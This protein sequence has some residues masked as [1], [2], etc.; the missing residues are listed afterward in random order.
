MLW[1]RRWRCSG[2]WRPDEVPDVMRL[3]LQIFAG[4][5]GIVRR[6]AR[7]RCHHAIGDGQ[8][9]QIPIGWMNEL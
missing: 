6:V 8:L 4:W 2:S 9:K 5:R 1:V 3:V 7:S